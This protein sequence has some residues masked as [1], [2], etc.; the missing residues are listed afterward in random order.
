MNVGLNA[1]QV[2]IPEGANLILGQ[3]HF[4]KTAEDI[5]EIVI[6]SV[7]GV[8]YG[9]AF[10]EA[11][12]PALIRTEGNSEELVKAA[13]DNALAI[14]AGHTFVL[15]IKNAFPINILNQIKNCHEVASVFAATANPLQVITAETGQGKG[16]MGVIDGSSPSGVENSGDKQARKE[17]LRKF[18]YK[19]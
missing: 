15:L 11:S 12:G 8:E 2:K 3:S 10:C 17:M 1:V 5:A 14:G 7:P 13:S 9:L 18:G 19:F 6:G 4:I 16:I